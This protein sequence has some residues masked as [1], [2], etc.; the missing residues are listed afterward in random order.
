MHELMYFICE[1]FKLTESFIREYRKDVN[2]RKICTEQICDN[3]NFL[4]EFA[5]EID[6]TYVAGYGRTIL[7]QEQKKEFLNYL[8]EEWRNLQP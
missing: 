3:T 6:W 1:N 2:W 7:T 4:R 5:D 8:P